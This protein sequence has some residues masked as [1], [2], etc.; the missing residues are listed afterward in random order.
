MNP[1]DKKRVAKANATEYQ[2]IPG[3]ISTY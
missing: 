3:F 1:A 2:E